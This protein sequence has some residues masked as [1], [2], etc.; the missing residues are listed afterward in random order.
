MFINV[1]WPKNK[2]LLPLCF[3]LLFCLF[4]FVVVVF[5][6]FDIFSGTLVRTGIQVA[7]SCYASFFFK[8][9]GYL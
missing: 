9:K 2:S 5:S 6:I 4:L 1:V 8:N 7:I 3:A